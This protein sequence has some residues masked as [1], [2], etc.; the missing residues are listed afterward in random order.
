MVGIPLTT[1]SIL[2]QLDETYADGK[3]KQLLRDAK[4]G[5][6]HTT[7]VTDDTLVGGIKSRR[8]GT[9]VVWDE[10]NKKWQEYTIPKI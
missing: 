7:T 9:N 10:E 2:N 5:E 8:Q 1:V 6:F 4:K 3:G